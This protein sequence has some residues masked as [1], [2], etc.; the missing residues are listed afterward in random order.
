MYASLP[1]SLLLHAHGIQFVGFKFV[2]CGQ[3]VDKVECGIPEQ[4]HTGCNFGAQLPFCHSLFHHWFIIDSMVW[5]NASSCAFRLSWAR[6]KNQKPICHPH[7]GLGHSHHSP[8]PS[9]L[10]SC[11]PPLQPQLDPNL[12]GPALSHCPLLLSWHPGH[13]FHLSS[14]RQHKVHH[15]WHL[16]KCALLRLACLCPSDPL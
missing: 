4:T 11:A 1:T 9:P 14:H 12:L 8:P 7:P 3:S 2:C 10:L 16:L 15:S 5:L 13:R 6:E